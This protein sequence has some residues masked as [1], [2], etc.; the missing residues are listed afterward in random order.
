MMNIELTDIVRLGIEVWIVAVEPVHAPM[1]FEV[2]LLQETPEAGATHGLRPMALLE[3]PDQI[4]ETPPG[5]GTMI[6]GGLLGGHRQH[7]HPLRGGKS[8]AGDPTAAHLAGPGVHAPDSDDAN[9]QRCAAHSPSRWPPVHWM[10][11]LAR[12]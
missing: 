1:R 4:I 3:G 5:S 8:A 7:V 11:H 2:R 6:R 12:R 9:A 10:G